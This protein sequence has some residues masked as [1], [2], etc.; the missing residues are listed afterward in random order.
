MA[1][2]IA[3]YVEKYSCVS[4]KQ[5]AWICRNAGYWKLKRPVELANVLIEN[6]PKSSAAN[7]VL[8]D[9]VTK[10]ILRCLR[11]IEKRIADG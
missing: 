2:G 8:S 3:E 9:D 4:E 5:A 7:H 1:E 6:A 10:E 11:R